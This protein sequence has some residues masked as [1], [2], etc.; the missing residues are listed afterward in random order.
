MHD[1]WLFDECCCPWERSEHSSNSNGVTDT[2]AHWQFH[3]LGLHAPLLS[4]GE[5]SL[6]GAVANISLSI[7]TEL[8]SLRCY[9]P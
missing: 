1:F 9:G 3:S 7:G 6:L 5:L 2:T 8:S 4:R